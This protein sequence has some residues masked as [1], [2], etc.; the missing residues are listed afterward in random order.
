MRVVTALGVLVA[1]ALV[2]LAGL[3]PVLAQGKGYSSNWQ[4]SFIEAASPVMERINSF[5]NF[6]LIIIVAIAVFVMLLM[7]YVVVRFRASANPV[8]S[9][10]THNPLIEVMWTVIPVLI[11][12]VI[13]VP[14]FRLLFFQDSV[15]NPEMTLRVTGHQWFWT[16][17]YPDQGSF[18][19]DAVMLQDDE[20]KEGQ[21][22]LLETDNRV[23]LPVDTNIRIEITADDVIHAWAIPAFGVKSDA[24]PGRI[25]ATWTRIEREG[26]YYGQCME[27]CGINHGFM[28]I[29][30]EAV[31]KE[32]FE[33]WVVDAQA[34]FA[35]S[36]SPAD[37]RFAERGAILGA[38]ELAQ[39]HAE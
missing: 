23:V 15:P 10:V 19:F 22:R 32:R 21:L 20:L 7:G 29:V 25:N 8:P 35:R 4:I 31:S 26:V 37:R 17:E 9:K 33:A 12:A 24:V 18:V 14:S 27:L 13:A 28:P 38:D 3:S 11:L 2:W 1:G 36:T 39:G 30:V 16:Y 34:K 5:H 6:V